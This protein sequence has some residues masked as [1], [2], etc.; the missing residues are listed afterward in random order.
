MKTLDKIFQTIR[1]SAS[2]WECHVLR[3]ALENVSQYFVFV[4]NLEL[5]RPRAEVVLC[6]LFAISP[7]LFSLSITSDYEVVSINL[8]SRT[9][10]L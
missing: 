7:S 1:T 4:S 2:S 9:N 6:F 5:F 8:V 3:P 10:L